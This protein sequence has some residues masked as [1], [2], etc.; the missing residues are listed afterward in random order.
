ML[1]GRALLRMSSGCV[2][3]L[4]LDCITF[5]NDDRSSAWE[6]AFGTRVEYKRDLGFRV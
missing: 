2:P 1:H 6:L 5:S 4:W 3:T